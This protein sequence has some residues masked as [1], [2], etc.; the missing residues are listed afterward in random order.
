MRGGADQRPPESDAVTR[1]QAA[2]D[3][4]TK[5][6]TENVRA[7]PDELKKKVAAAAVRAAPDEL[8]DDVTAA[9]IAATPD[10]LKKKV[11]AAAVRA[12]P[13]EFK[14]DVTA[15]AIAATPDK[16]KKEVTTAAVR[17]LP[18]KMKDAA[19]GA[20]VEAVLTARDSE[21]SNLMETVA[22]AVRDEMHEELYGPSL[23]N[24]EG[25]LGIYVVAED[26]N[27]LPI[28]EDRSISM[29]RGDHYSLVLTIGAAA[30]AN[31]D[32]T[33]PLR[34]SGGVDADQVEFSVMLNGDDP[35][36]LQT[37]QSV[38]VATANGS[39]SASFP[40][41]ARWDNPT[42]LWLRVAQRGEFIQHVELTVRLHEGS[43]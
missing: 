20:A 35:E 25:Y 16:F 26:G 10:K 18:N 9:A 38:M 12:A 5:E 15:A 40:L 1:A 29:Q 13:D 32:L 4:L 36:L 17:A 27:K 42:R 28:N 39:A 19:A 21:H 41:E 31:A 2:T 7:A 30:D 14:D 3:K 22:R 37:A 34:I 8:K 6:V 43:S 33:L 23:I 24:Y 11:A